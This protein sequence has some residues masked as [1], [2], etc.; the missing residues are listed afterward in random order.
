LARVLEALKKQGVIVRQGEVA[1]SILEGMGAR[2]AYLPTPGGGPGL[3]YL[4]RN[5]TRSEVIE[6]LIHYAQARGR[7]FPASVEETR[8]MQLLQDEVGASKRM[9]D[10]AKRGGWSEAELQQFE[11]N[12]AYWTK[13]LQQAGGPP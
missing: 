12:L 11:S 2:A 10:L 5:A 7:G 8:A 13:R 3:L 1:E 6:E 9:I 4:G